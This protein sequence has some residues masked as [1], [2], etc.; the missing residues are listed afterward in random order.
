[1][2][3][4]AEAIPLQIASLLMKNGVRQWIGWQ[5]LNQITSKRGDLV[6]LN[7]D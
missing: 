3:S 5:A 2:D 6:S 1:M 7:T 4:G